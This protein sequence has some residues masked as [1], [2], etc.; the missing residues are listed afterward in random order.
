M[1]ALISPAKRLEEAPQQLKL[2][3]TQPAL[4]SQTEQLIQKL[5]KCSVKKLQALMDISS[6]LAELN[7]DRYQN[8]SLPFTKE[9]ATPAILTF[10]G[11]VYQGMNP[12]EFN[13]SDHR[14]AQNHLRI[15]SGLYGVL[16]PLDLMQPYRLEM[17]TE[18]S[19]GR[20]KNLYEF[21]GSTITD[22]INQALS[23]SGSDLLI[24]LASQE[25]FNA[26]QP[27]RIAGD[28]IT[29]VFKEEKNGKLRVLGMFAKK[30]RGMM[31]NHLIRNR[32][33]TLDDLKEFQQAGYC[34]DEALSKGNQLIFVRPQPAPVSAK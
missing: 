15:L 26:I 7:Y 18:I 6:D 20:R 1:L 22:E 25:Y 2:E 27:K 19:I 12:K 33:K 24:N 17:G 14:Y 5:K 16:R 10:N 29:P 31:V 11:E 4:L 9:N 32:V 8:W 3:L 30:A 23:E 21:W 28:I 34:Y 13:T